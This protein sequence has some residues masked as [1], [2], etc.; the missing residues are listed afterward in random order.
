[1]PQLRYLLSS[2]VA[3]IL[4]VPVAAANTNLST[5]LAGA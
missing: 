3:V 4:A 1:V 2:V 5:K